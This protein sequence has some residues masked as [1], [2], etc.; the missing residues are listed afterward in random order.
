MQRDVQQ[1]LSNLGISSEA[2]G[3]GIGAKWQAGGAGSLKVLSPI[4]G[5][6]LAE[7]P[8]ATV[9]QVNETIEEA[10]RAFAIWRDT[11]APV[12]GELVRR[13]GN[14]F[15]EHEDDLATLVTME[16]GKI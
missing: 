9:E 8:A 12:R 13:I 2:C 14:M 7:F 15:R 4:D 11:P 10:S 16:V 6:R 5:S 1:V 3:V